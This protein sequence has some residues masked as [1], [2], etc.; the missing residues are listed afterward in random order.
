MCLSKLVQLK[1]YYRWEAIFCKFL[2]KLAI[3]VPLD[4]NSHEFKAIWK[5]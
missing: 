3:L 4:H 2:E 5:N 1:R